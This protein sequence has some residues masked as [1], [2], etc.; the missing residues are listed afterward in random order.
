MSG[1]QTIYIVDDDEA[2]RDSLELVLGM[3][4]WTVHAFSSAQSF[5][6]AYDSAWRGCLLL[7]IRMPGIDGRGLQRRLG[8]L[9]RRL[10]IPAVAEL[11]RRAPRE[12]RLRTPR[13]DLAREDVAHL[14]LVAL[15]PGILGHGLLE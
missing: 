8:E 13:L 1:T 7:D 11:P 2:I 5:L 4:G 9:A 12:G 15:E 10:G 3:R 6:D 14:G